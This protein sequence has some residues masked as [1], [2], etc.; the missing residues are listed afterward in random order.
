MNESHTDFLRKKG[1]IRVKSRKYRFT[2]KQDSSLINQIV[3]R[4]SQLSLFVT[5][6]NHR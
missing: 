6:T 4:L 3:S 2:A 1:N 5:D